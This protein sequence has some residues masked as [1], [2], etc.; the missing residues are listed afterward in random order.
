MAVRRAMLPT[1]ASGVVADAM[2]REPSYMRAALNAA[3]E[4]TK[5]NKQAAANLLGVYRPRLYNMIRK[6]NLQE[7]AEGE[8]EQGEEQED[9]REMAE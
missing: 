4:R 3:L 6:H 1:L 9:E 5:G 8:E 2:S 7:I